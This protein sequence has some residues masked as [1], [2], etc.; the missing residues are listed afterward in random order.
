MNLQDTIVASATGNITSALGIVRL[1]GTNAVNIMSKVFL[2]ISKQNFLDIAKAN[3]LYYGQIIKDRESDID[4]EN[5]IDEV[6]VSVFRSPHSFTGEDTVEITHHGS[7]F[8]SK[9]IINL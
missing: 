3:T 4:K 7:T 8:M 6:V 9:E 2:P 5:I 1:S